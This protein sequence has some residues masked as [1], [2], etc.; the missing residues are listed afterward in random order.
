MSPDDAFKYTSFYKDIL[1]AEAREVGEREYDL[2]DL[3]CPLSKMKAAELI[4]NLN[5]GETAK[6]ILDDADS[7]KSVAQELKT[8]GIKPDFEL[9]GEEE[10]LKQG[11]AWV[12]S[13]GV[14]VD[15][16]TGDIVE[17]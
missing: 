11:I 4:D 9:G 7:L 14:R 8:G 1:E 5:V 16:V 12:T 15:P 17:G 10:D 3:V 13:K 2:C 6:I